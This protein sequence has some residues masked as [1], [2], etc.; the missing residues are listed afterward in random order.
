[1]V[2]GELQRRKNERSIGKEKIERPMTEIIVNPLKKL[3]KS[4]QVEGT[5]PAGGSEFSKE[6]TDADMPF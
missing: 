3:G 5:A 6:I 1:M 2:E 4:A